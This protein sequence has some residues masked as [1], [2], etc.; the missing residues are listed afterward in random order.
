MKPER[1]RTDPTA[2]T[3]QDREEIA[4]LFDGYATPAVAVDWDRFVD[5]FHPAMIRL[6]PD[7]QTS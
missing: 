5:L 4:A 3:S 2:L 1:A 7:L 6:Y